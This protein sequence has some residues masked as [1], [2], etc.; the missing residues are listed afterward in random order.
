MSKFTI[1]LFWFRND[2]RLQDNTALFHAL[3]KHKNVQCLFI[4][5]RNILSGLSKNDRRVTFI[6]K[7]LREMNDTLYKYGSSLLVK[8][9]NPIE[10]FKE[11]LESF[12]IEGIYLNND[13]EPY[14]LKRDREI[15][16]W[17]VDSNIPFYSYK[18]AVIFEKKEVL[19]S[20][21]LPYTVFTPYSRKW[22]L[23]F[24]Q[25]TLIQYNI[26]S[27]SNNFNHS[28]K[29]TFPFIE[30]IGFKTNQFIFPE[31]K[32]DEH[33]VKNYALNRNFPAL[34]GTSRLGI[35]LRFGTISIRE[36]V[37]FAHKNS[38]VWLNELIWREF[39]KMI[40]FHFPYVEKNA[41]RKQFDSIK[42]LDD[43]ESFEK[44]CAGQTGYPIVDAGMRELV[45][46]G[47]MH[48]RARMITAGFLVKHLLIDWRKGETF[49]AKHLLDYDLS[50]NNGNWQWAAGTGCDAAPY[51]RI[52]NP[53]VQAQKFDKNLSYIRHWVPEYDT[54]K[55]YPQIVEHEFA[56]KRSL[57]VLKSFLNNT[58]GSL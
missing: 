51:Y 12:N 24:S 23:S 25:E 48:N 43:D 53:I 18:D 57:T 37:T 15:E 46:T 22:L 58:K 30:E 10:V 8:T 13:Y 42:W 21:G 40:L 29:H 14:A 44:W 9:G 39:F 19:K 32:L 5:D 20:D 7:E 34:N 27:Y 36:A 28:S 55:Y 17:A 54:H 4:F 3:K 49:F 1:T 6:Y 38:S 52:F 47:F 50:A 11:L 41:F 31:K 33:C 35:H 26:I 45:A 56:R 2:L 16:M